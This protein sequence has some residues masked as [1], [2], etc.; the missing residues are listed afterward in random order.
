[1]L[2]VYGCHAQR[3]QKRALGL[4]E[5]ELKTM[6]ATSCGY[7]E[8]NSLDHWASLYHLGV[9]ILQGEFTFQEGG[10]IRGLSFLLPPKVLS[11][12]VHFKQGHGSKALLRPKDNFIN[13]LFGGKQPCVLGR[14]KVPH[15]QQI[16]SLR[17]Q[18]APHSPL[19]SVT[20]GGTLYLIAQ[21]Q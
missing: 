9:K 11:L 18:P 8:P 12:L 19:F 2:G 21:N 16:P 6:W 15:S 13:L 3:D 7:W 10:A 14:P 20:H 17:R 5:M 1:M 4:P